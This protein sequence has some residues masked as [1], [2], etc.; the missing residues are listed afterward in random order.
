[1]ATIGGSAPRSQTIMAI[2]PGNATAGTDQINV[3]GLAPFAGR[4][5]SVDY[6]PNAAITGVATN[7]RQMDVINK[8]QAG[9]GSTVAFRKA[10][11]SG[12]NATAFA[13]NSIPANGAAANQVVA[14]GDVLVWLS[15]AIASGMV[16]PGGL[17]AVVISNDA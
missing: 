8:G 13:K 2:V 10:Y 7:Y 4:I 1:M 5:V 9:A 14:A 17:L 11:D 12:K 3:I 16:D 15:D 6:L